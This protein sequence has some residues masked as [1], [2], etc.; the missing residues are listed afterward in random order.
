MQTQPMSTQIPKYM[1]AI[2][3][4]E[5]GGPEVLQP[6]QMHTPT[7]GPQDILIKVTAAGVNRP[8][9]LQRQGRPEGHGERDPQFACPK[10]LVTSD[11]AG[12]DTVGSFHGFNQYSLA[13]GRGDHG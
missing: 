9:C 5:S 8:D 1:T 4:S 10:T 12:P 7:P 13:A 6:V 11:E 2:A 3:I